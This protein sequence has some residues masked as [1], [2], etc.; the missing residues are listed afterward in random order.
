MKRKRASITFLLFSLVFLV[1]VSSAAVESDSYRITTSVFSGGG[2]AMDSP[3]YKTNATLG[4]PSPLMDPGNPPHSASFS[5]Y[6]GFWY[7]L[8]MPSL[9][10]TGPTITVAMVQACD[11]G[12]QTEVPIT[13]N[14]TAG[15]TGCSFFVSFDNTRLQY[16]GQTAGNMGAF[17]LLPSPAEINAAGKVQPIV[18]F[19]EGGATSG[20]ICKFKFTL[21]S[22]IP[23]GS[24][25]NLTIGDILPESTYCGESGAVTCGG[26]V[27]WDDIIET[28]NDYINGTV[29]WDEVIAAYQAYVNQ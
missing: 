16:I 6:P 29:T 27:T 12:A 1:I 2:V 11:Q 22:T 7:T 19:E 3:S 21:L 14:D 17:L 13:I 9:P 4:Q 20:T 18:Q 8:G 15:I 5:L 10:C 23:E 28:Y 24:Q 26:E 25:V